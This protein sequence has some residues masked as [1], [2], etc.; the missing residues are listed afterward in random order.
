MP[1]LSN[2]SAG[3]LRQALQLREQI[4]SLQQQ[5]STVL[6]TSDARSVHLSA[7][8]RKSLGNKESAGKR[9]M[10]ADARRKIAAAQKARWSQQKQQKKVGSPTGSGTQPASPSGAQH[11][12]RTLSPEA[13]AKIAEAQRKRWAAQ[14]K[15][16][17]Q[18]SAS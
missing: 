11:A 5:L 4:D 17:W 7:A 13:R 15:N 2:L 6:S 16:A 9:T 12:K 18:S 3:Q 8:A 1:S 10:S 14:K